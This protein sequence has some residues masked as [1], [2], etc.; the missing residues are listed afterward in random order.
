MQWNKRN[1]ELPKC[2]EKDSDLGNVNDGWVP[3]LYYFQRLFSKKQ[4][5]EE[6]AIIQRILYK[7]TLQHRKSAHLRKLIEL[8]RC[9]KRFRELDLAEIMNH[10]IPIKTEEKN[11]YKLPSREMVSF[12]LTRL[13]GGYKLLSKTIN[14]LEDTYIAFHTILRQAL[15]MPFALIVMSSTSRLHIY[16]QYLLK[17]MNICYK[18]TYHW[19]STLKQ[20]ENKKFEIGLS[21]NIEDIILHKRSL[22]SE[23]ANYQSIQQAIEATNNTL[24]DDDMNEDKKDDDI[25]E[26][27]PIIVEENNNELSSSFWG[28][29]DSNTHQEKSS[30][31][32]QTSTSNNNLSSKNKLNKKNKKNLNQK[33]KK[34]SNKS[35]NDIIDNIFDSLPFSISNKNKNN[36]NNQPKDDKDEEEDK[37]EDDNT[38]GL[39]IID[40]LFSTVKD[41]ADDVHINQ[42][43]T[44]TKKGMNKKNKKRNF[45]EMSNE[46]GNKNNSVDLFDDDIDKIFSGKITSKTV[47]R[48]L[49]K[50]KYGGITDQKSD[51]N[52]VINKSQKKSKINNKKQNQ[53][54]NNNQSSLEL[55]T[56]SYLE[57]VLKRQEEQRVEDERQNNILDKRMKE[58]KK[59]KKQ[60]K[61][62]KI[63]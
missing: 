37:K 48:P 47:V 54:R 6:I 18:M 46:E 51:S 63:H 14:I 17:E 41:D 15:F 19:M 26:E 49:D 45:G 40:K 9:L 16:F 56:D 4:L 8:S 1:I 21:E 20:V 44:N 11:V 60:Q 61:K 39:D 33:K 50:L 43:Q 12:F 10:I 23:Y 59:N 25:K 29:L 30:M 38:S 55:T 7:N 5:W 34:N 52:K 24:N 3:K 13:V 31:L 22:E 36:N 42:K 28:I 53:H 57:K 2:Q 27:K 58:M 62:K 32:N 35:E